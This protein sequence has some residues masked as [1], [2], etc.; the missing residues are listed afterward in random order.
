MASYYSEACRKLG[1]ES[2]YFSMA[3]GK[4]PDEEADVYH[5]VNIFDKDTIVDI[6]RE[7]GA[8]GI[9]PTTEL[10]VS[11]AAYVADKL[12]WPGNPVDVAKVI[13]DKYRNRK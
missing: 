13:T 1:Y 10:S 6:C 5:E 8:T 11:I 2:H 3:D 9:V 7:I 12:G 4:I